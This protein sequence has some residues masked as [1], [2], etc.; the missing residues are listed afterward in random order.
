MPSTPAGSDDACRSTDTSGPEHVADSFD[1]SETDNSEIMPN[2]EPTTGGETDVSDVEVSATDGPTAARLGNIAGRGGLATRLNPQAACFVPSQ[3]PTQEA[4][5]PLLRDSIRSVIRALEDWERS[6]AAE[7]LYSRQ[8][9]HNSPTKPL[10]SHT[11]SVLQQALA[12]LS[13]QDAALVRAFVD[14]KL[15][16]SPEC[17]PFSQPTM[18]GEHPVPDPLF[19]QQE[20]STVSSRSNH[21]RNHGSFL[22]PTSLVEAGPHRQ[23]GYT[24]AAKGPQRWPRANHT[25]K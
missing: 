10:Q 20:A 18:A 5:R 8:E 4:S 22:L 25:A 23:T 7:E 9:N 21:T 13:L 11:L 6:K 24:R 12:N 16:L 19:D 1:G 3:P 14:S 17:Q 2:S 15:A